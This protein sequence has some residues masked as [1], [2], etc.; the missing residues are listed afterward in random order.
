MTQPTELTRRSM[1]SQS[2]AALTAASGSIVISACGADVTDSTDGATNVLFLAVVPLTTLTYSPELLADAGGYFADEG[3]NVEFQ[4]TRGSAQ[5]IQLVLADGAP[6]TRV[7]QIEAVS[8]IVN[9]EAPIMNIGTVVKDSAIRIVSSV[10]APL[11]EPADFVGKTLGIPSEGG[12]SETTLDLLLASGGVDPDDVERQVVGVGPGVFN[13]VEQGRIAGFMVSIDTAKILERQMEGVVVLKPGEFIDA[14]S[15]LYML[16][17]DGVARH[18]DIARRYLRSIRRAIDF[19]V[20]DDGFDASLE[21]MRRKYSFSTLQDD[22]VAKDSLTEYVDAWTSAGDNNI[23][24]TDESRW[25][26]GYDELVRAGRIAA[27]HDPA[28]WY[29]NEFI[30]SP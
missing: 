9:R 30:T 11:R 19:I 16:S 1:L 14:G 22:A 23:L 15:Q 27:G 24:R 13:L 8:H 18:G 25:R 29:T 4:S 7:G 20:A 10:A 5:A 28:N 6:L 21:I 3:L 17:A 12:E 2:A 26:A